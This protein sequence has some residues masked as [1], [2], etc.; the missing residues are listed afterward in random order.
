[1]TTIVDGAGIYVETGDTERII[2]VYRDKGFEPFVLDGPLGDGLEEVVCIG[3]IDGDDPQD[4][5]EFLDV[6]DR[7]EGAYKSADVLY[8]YEHYE[9]AEARIIERGYPLERPI[10]DAEGNNIT[11][12]TPGI[13]L[14]ND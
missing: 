5:D 4:L 8:R 11:G 1:M 2:K 10:R 6:L 9:E 13:C 7:L 12:F 3:S 14:R